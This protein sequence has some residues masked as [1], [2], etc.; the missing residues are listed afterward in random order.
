M[1]L[2]DSAAS[3]EASKNKKLHRKL[4]D[5]VAVWETNDYYGKDFC[6]KLRET[7]ETSGKLAGDSQQKPQDNGPALNGKHHSKD[8]TVPATLPAIH[9]DRTGHWSDLL[10]GC[11][12]PLIT[13]NSKRPIRVRELKPFETNSRSA[14]PAMIEAVKDLFKEADH[15][16]MPYRQ[17]KTGT[18]A[19][20]DQMGQ[21]Y[22]REKET[23]ELK[24]G[25]TYYGWSR[26]FAESM[27]KRQRDTTQ[28]R[29]DI[30][31]ARNR[32]RSRSFSP[33]KRPRH[34]SYSDR[35]YTRSRTPSW[36]QSRRSYTRSPSRSQARPSFEGP[37]R[38]FTGS[39]SRIQSYHGDRR[40]SYTGSPSHSRPYYDERRHSY[41][42]S[43]SHSRSYHNDHRSPRSSS[44]RHS[45]RPP[46]RHDNRGYG[47]G[48]QAFGAL[49]G[50]FPMGRPGRG[51][52]VGFPSI[53][54]AGVAIPPRP[55]NWTGPW[56]PPAP[57]PPPPQA[58]QQGPGP[59]PGPG[60]N[61]Y[62]GSWG[63]MP[64]PFPGGG[65]GRGRQGWGR[66]GWRG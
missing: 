44:P 60:P 45:S 38:S 52:G 3:F 26:K 6:S 4:R 16:Y 7:L 57:P 42:R 23:G 15:I 27:R 5:L 39:P 62:G 47:P 28:D 32:S 41:T 63:G 20:I 34:D 46:S 58:F 8:K 18:V 1:E 40:G 31:N 29:G 37:R 66:D 2:V 65:R 12:V 61:G 17:H 22:Y 11:M 53:S 35:S 13:R 51:Q 55:P 48:E 9:G 54:P 64:M 50:T 19:N 14:H 21:P 24:S 25:D 49:I 36:T 30:R 10:A 33:H 43:P 59:G 56:P